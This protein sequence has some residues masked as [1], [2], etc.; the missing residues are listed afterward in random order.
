[1]YQGEEEEE[2]EEKGYTTMDRSDKEHRCG[3]TLIVH[4]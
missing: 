4:S 3:F 2:E 1:V